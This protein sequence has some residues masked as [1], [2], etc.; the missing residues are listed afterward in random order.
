VEQLAEIRPQA[1]P[2]ILLPVC[3][4]GTLMNAHFTQVGKWRQKAVGMGIL[5]KTSRYVRRR[6]ADEFAV[7]PG[8]SPLSDGPAVY[9]VKRGRKPKKPVEL[10]QAA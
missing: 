9:K 4:I 10:D 6:L 7:K 1:R 2:T 8:F 3:S 5:S